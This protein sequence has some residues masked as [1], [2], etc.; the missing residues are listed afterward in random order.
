M[1]RQK[2]IG[3]GAVFLAIV[4]VGSDRLFAQEGPYPVDPQLIEIGRDYLDTVYRFDFAAQAT[5]YTPESVF[6]D[7][8]V[9]ILGQSWHFTGPE[10]IVDFFRGTLP[11]TEL[12][13]RV[14][15]QDA[16]VVADRVHFYVHYYN[17][18]DG[19]PLGYPGTQMEVVARG[20]T[21]LRIVEGKVLHH[22][23]YIDYPGMFRQAAE[24]AAAQAV[25]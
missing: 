1:K 6:E 19:T 8:T 12:L 21:I 15:I 14:D 23:D 22:L 25:R 13:V 20:F 10:E 7:H 3:V 18:G 9:D 17:A 5:F 11:D 24:Q 16:F 4:L 2:V